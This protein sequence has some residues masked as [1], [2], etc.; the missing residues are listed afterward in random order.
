MHVALT[1][2]TR[3]CGRVSVGAA[4][5]SMECDIHRRRVRVAPAIGYRAPGGYSGDEGRWLP[6]PTFITSPWGRIQ[7]GATAPD[8]ARVTLFV[9]VNPD[10]APCEKNLSC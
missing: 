8:S 6:P 7:R 2:E 4:Q 9:G 1:T 10:P 5:R 3:V